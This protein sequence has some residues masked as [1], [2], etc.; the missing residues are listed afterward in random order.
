MSLPVWLP[1]DRA[2]GESTPVKNKPKTMPKGAKGQGNLDK[3]VDKEV[4]DQEIDPKDP[5]EWAKALISE[6]RELR[7]E[8][9]SLNTQLGEKIAQA[10]GKIKGLED[11]VEELEF[12]SRKYNLLL[13][14]L[15]NVNSANCEEKVNAFFRAELGFDRDLDMAACHPVRGETVIMR[16]VRLSDRDAVLKCGNK[17]K[18]KKLS[19]KTDLPPRLRKIR[20]ELRAEA[21]QMRG[22]GKVVRV[23]EKGRGVY[24]QEKQG[25]NWKTL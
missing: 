5:P 20:A 17:L 21:K 7:A 11:K 18:G 9:G 22:D 8:I 12:N 6:F 13:W 25:N 10:E 19:L 2:R 14:G 1:F 3:F 4:G 15:S 16:F 24:L 23:I